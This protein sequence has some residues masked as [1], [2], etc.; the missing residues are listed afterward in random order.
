M[1]HSREVR[2]DA[3]VRAGDRTILV[4]TRRITIKRPG[5]CMESMTPVAIVILEGEACSMWLLDKSVTRE[6]IE[7]LLGGGASS[8]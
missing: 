1:M 7:T 4:I 6:E 3:A 2:L 5:S 8:P